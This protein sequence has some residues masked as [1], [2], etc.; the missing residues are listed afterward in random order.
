MKPNKLTRKT[1]S[2]LLVL[3]IAAG[4]FACLQTASAQRCQDSYI[5]RPEKGNLDFGK[6]RGWRTCSGFFFVLQADGILALFD[7]KGN[8][9]WSLA[10]YIRADTLSVQSD[11]NVVLYKKGRP[12]WST[13]TDNNKGAYFAIQGDG[14]LVVYSRHGRVLW[15][16]D[17]G[18][19]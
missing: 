2:Y 12:V 1:G 17:T 14:N 5:F 15:S 13:G 4:L 6:G 8:A 19:I 7:R 11:G 18:G 9:I 16:S 3:A 10:T